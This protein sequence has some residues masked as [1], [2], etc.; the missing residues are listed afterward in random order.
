VIRLFQK[1]QQAPKR[2]VRGKE[3]KFFEG[4]GQHTKEL[5]SKAIVHGRGFIEKEGRKK[6]SPPKR[7]KAFQYCWGGVKRV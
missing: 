4:L 5:D 2:I 6:I 1:E 7:P 3:K